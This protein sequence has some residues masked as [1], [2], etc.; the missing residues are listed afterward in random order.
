MTSIIIQTEYRLK[1]MFIHFFTNTKKIQDFSQLIA[2]SVN[3]T[4]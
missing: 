2:G 1:K 4:Q 3:K